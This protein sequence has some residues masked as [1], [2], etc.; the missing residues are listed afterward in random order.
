MQKQRWR[1]PHTTHKHAL[2]VEPKP[3]LE[4]YI[5]LL[6]T[7]RVIFNSVSLSS[8]QIFFGV[9]SLAFTGIVAVGLVFEYRGSQSRNRNDWSPWTGEPKRWDMEQIGDFLIVIGVVGEFFF[10]CI[11]LAI[12]INLDTDQKREIALLEQ[13]VGPRYLSNDAVADLL[14]KIKPFSGE[15]VGLLVY[16]S[17][18]DGD[19]FAAQLSHILDSAHWQISWGPIHWEKREQPIFGIWIELGPNA[20]AYDQHAAEALTSGLKP[21]LGTRYTGA[22]YP[23]AVER[24][25]WVFSTK[26]SVYVTIANKPIR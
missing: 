9:L 4:L 18:N 5:W 24:A 23:E 2:S 6:K 20:K 13:R 3:P 10:G 15:T 7:P 14:T 11:A 12:T 8:A 1:I 17:A 19:L 25:G 16:D 21:Y 22:P 26:P